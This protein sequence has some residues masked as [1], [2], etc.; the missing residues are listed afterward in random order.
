[1]F[2]KKFFGLTLVLA[3]LATAIF[4]AFNAPAVY[5]EAPIIVPSHGKPTRQPTVSPCCDECGN[6]VPCPT[7]PGVSTATPGEPPVVVPSNTPGAT[8]TL[9]EPGDNPTPILGTPVSVGTSTPMPEGNPWNAP[10]YAWGRLCPVENNG[11]LLMAFPWTTNVDNFG[12]LNGDADIT[13]D[14]KPV[15]TTGHGSQ[16]NPDGGIVWNQYGQFKNFIAIPLDG[17]EH[18]LTMKSR[19]G[20]GDIVETLKVSKDDTTCALFI[21]HA[22]LEQASILDYLPYIGVFALFGLLVFFIVRNRK[23]AAVKNG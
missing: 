22:G 20:A 23:A 18:V 5:A 4:S 9:V 11:A 21:Q 14:G 15:T 17:K 16:G 6:P 7:Q 13:L 19:L 3:I 1:M 10:S 2:T 8:A 12:T